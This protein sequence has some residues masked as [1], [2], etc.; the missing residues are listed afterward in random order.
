MRNE[1]TYIFGGWAVVFLSSVSKNVQHSFK[2]GMRKRSKSG[3]KKKSS[4]VLK[5]EGDT[6]SETKGF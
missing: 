6:L 1:I 2:Y 3:E 4:P 5:K